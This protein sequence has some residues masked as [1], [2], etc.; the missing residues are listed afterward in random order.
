MRVDLCYRW[1]LAESRVWSKPPSGS[2][3]Y[4][5]S[6]SQASQ[7]PRHRAY[8]KTRNLPDMA[9]FHRTAGCITSCST[10]VLLRITASCFTTLKLPMCSPLRL[11]YI[12]ETAVIFQT[13]YTYKRS[14]VRLSASI[15][16]CVYSLSRL[17]SPDLVYRL[18]HNPTANHANITKLP[19]P[20]PDLAPSL[21]APFVSTRFMLVIALAAL[22]VA[23]PMPAFPL[24]VGT[25]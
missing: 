11:L 1:C 18:L 7:E 8:R 25:P 17:T 3:V 20:P 24:G 19:N 12:H 21:T 2:K 9:A 6:Q 13:L 5:A 15:L 10:R 22:L 23:V 16:P 4:V 14:H